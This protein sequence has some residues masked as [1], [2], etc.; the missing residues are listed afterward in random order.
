MPELVL[1][2]DPTEG[3][4]TLTLNRPDK[5]NA[6]S[7][8]LRDAVSDTLNALAGRDD[9]KVVVLTGAGNVFCA[10]FDLTEFEQLEDDPALGNALWASSDRFHRTVVTFPL[11]LVAAVNGPALAGGFDLAVMCD[12][13][14][15]ADTARFAHPELRFPEAVYSPLHDLV[16]GAVARELCLTGRTLDAHEALGLRLVSS[17]VPHRDL[18]AE[19][20]RVAADIAGAPREVLLRMKEKIVRRS[21]IATTTGLDL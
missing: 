7:I 10:G 11:P 8:A 21:G 14:V 12:L 19:A 17:I 16:G 18:P 1:M 4:A 13:R 3:V 20:H 5:R 9:I 6:L 2:S 15:A